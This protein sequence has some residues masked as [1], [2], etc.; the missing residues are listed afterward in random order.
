MQM[1]VARPLPEKILKNGFISRFAI[2]VFI[3]RNN[4]QNI[5]F[6]WRNYNDMYQS[7]D[8]H[9]YVSFDNYSK[10]RMG[11]YWYFVSQYWVLSIGGPKGRDFGLH[12]IPRGPEGRGS[13]YT[14]SLA[15]AVRV[16]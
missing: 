1:V 16:T 3:L 15:A 12:K 6:F 9:A 4:N 14:K 13:G 11:H 7:M 5:L 8:L 2:Y 10:V